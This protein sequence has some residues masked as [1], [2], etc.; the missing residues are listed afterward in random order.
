[1]FEKSLCIR[2][3]NLAKK[4]ISEKELCDSIKVFWKEEKQLIERLSK[5]I[6]ARESE[7]T[8]IKKEE[9]FQPKKSKKRETFKA[10]QPV[11]RPPH[12]KL[13]ENLI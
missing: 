13:S 1:M 8:N 4:N 11:K 9:E 3:I 7:L 5:K 10:W 2:W 6:Y 12:S